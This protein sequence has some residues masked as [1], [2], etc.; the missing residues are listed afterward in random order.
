MTDR[1]C[2]SDPAKPS[3]VTA[4]PDALAGFKERKL[5]RTVR[6]G[7]HHRR[8]SCVDRLINRGHLFAKLVRLVVVLPVGA[9]TYIE[10]ISLKVS[11]K[12][13]RRKCSSDSRNTP[14]SGSE[15]RD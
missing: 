8:W 5:Q 3:V 4:L 15:G 6:V 11:C 14:L 2:A 13:D 10:M 9:L 1:I 12:H 7:L